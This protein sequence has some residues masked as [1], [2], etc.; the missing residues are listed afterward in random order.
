ML[1]YLPS[2]AFTDPSSV[3]NDFFRM[4]SMF[5]KIAALAALS[6]ISSVASRKT[7][8]PNRAPKNA[9]LLSNVAALTFHGDKLTSSR[10][11]AAVPQLTCV[12]P[13]D[14]CRL[15]K[16]D[17]IRCTSEGADY[18][19][20]NI[21]WSCKASLPEEFKLGS[22]D[23]QCEGYESSDDPYV[24]KGSC[25]CDYRLFLTDKGIEKYK[26]PGKA[27]S[28]EGIDGKESGSNP[29]V[30]GLFMILFF[31]VLFIILRSIW[32]QSR[33]D[34]PRLGG[35]TRPNDDGDDDPP[36]PYDSPPAPRTT[37]RRPNTSTPK[38]TASSNRSQAGNART[39]E[40]PQP[41][42][43]PGF[44]TGAALGAAGEYARHRNAQT[45]T[46]PRPRNSWFGNTRQ[47][48]M[49]ERPASSW[50]NSNPQ[51]QTQPQST[52]GWF[53]NNRNENRSSGS[54]T[55][56]SSRP[57]VPDHSSE[58]YESTGFGGTRRR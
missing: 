31:G 57:S 43:R 7:T 24:L 5:C 54:T 30:G 47:Q 14:V 17:T 48:P 35:R 40:A 1:S 20:M 45:Q 11:V 36:P 29:L 22:T 21:Q 12:G 52:N 25:A 38:T 55:G 56:S 33:R 42:W 28:S 19:P 8:D 44:W 51:P 34:L 53:S 9:V 10:R 27:W 6:F 16:V 46:E 49:Q 4:L 23:V 3:S 32:R 58:H 15:Y 18:D 26:K 13:E 41:G 37:P 2:R 50:W 39:N